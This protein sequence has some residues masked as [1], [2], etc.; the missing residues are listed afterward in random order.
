[1]NLLLFQPA[2]LSEDDKVFRD[3]VLLTRFEEREDAYQTLV[4]LF[5][6]VDNDQYPW[7]GKVGDFYLLRG[8]FNEEDEKGRRLSFLFASDNESYWEELNSVVSDIDLT[9]S[10]NTESLVSSFLEKSKKKR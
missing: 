2:V 4:R 8:L 10:D 1:M 7:I 9:L 6:G 5:D 3:G